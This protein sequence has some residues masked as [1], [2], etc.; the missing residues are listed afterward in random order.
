MTRG[1][2]LL[3]LQRRNTA[4]DH[5]DN[6][7]TFVNHALLPQPQRVIVFALSTDDV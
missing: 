2:W 1:V 6:S 4:I 7:T 5:T 3:C